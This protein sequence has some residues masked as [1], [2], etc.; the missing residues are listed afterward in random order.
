MPGLV[1]CHSKGTQ[2]KDLLIVHNHKFKI[3]F[4]LK[5]DLVSNLRNL[6]WFA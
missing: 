1:F 6:L 4:S 5:D 2:P 3:A